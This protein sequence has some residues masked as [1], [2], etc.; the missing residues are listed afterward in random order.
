MGIIREYGICCPVGFMALLLGHVSHLQGCPTFS[1][2]CITALSCSSVLS[3]ATLR[4]SLCRTLLRTSSCRGW[5]SWS[6]SC[7]IAWEST[8]ET[9]VTLAVPYTWSILAPPFGSKSTIWKRF[10]NT[11][12]DALSGVKTTS[13]V[14]LLWPGSKTSV[15]SVLTK[16]FPETAGEMRT[17]PTV[18]A[19]LSSWRVNHDRKMRL[20]FL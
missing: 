5:C 7:Q 14:A 6:A 9:R 19:L 8:S 13:S 15:P 18:S 17:R 16:S 12:K 11:L 10:G 1:S 3:V 2:K 20:L 4:L